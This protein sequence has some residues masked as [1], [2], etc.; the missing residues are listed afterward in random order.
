[1]ALAER[2]PAATGVRQVLYV[3][4]NAASEITGAAWLCQ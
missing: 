1:M 4:M 3:G 2:L